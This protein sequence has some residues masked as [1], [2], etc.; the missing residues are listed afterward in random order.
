MFKGF[1]IFSSGGNF[2][3]WSGTIFAI[4]LEGHHEI[5]L[6]LGHWPRRRCHMKKLFT[7]AGA[8]MTHE[9]RRTQGDHNS[10]L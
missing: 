3:Q 9:G 6:T 8:C 4:F 1:T 2:V 10:S 7:K 5:I